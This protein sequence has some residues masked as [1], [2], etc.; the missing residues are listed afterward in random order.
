MSSSIA[1]HVF[2]LRQ[3]LSLNPELTMFRL[4]FGQQALAILSPYHPHPH[5]GVTDA[6][7]G[8]QDPHSVIN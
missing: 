6:G 3:H 4:D 5:T 8:K 1:L 7:C 2:P